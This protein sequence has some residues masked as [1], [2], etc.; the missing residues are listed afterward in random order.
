MRKILDVWLENF[1]KARP[2]IK[3][4]AKNSIGEYEMPA[5]IRAAFDALAKE[6]EILS[7]RLAFAECALQNS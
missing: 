3:E 1:Y 7:E 6:N 2:K 5:N 4:P